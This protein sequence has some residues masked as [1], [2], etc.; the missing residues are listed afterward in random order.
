MK[1]SPIMPRCKICLKEISHS[2]IDSLLPFTFP[3][4]SLCP[5]CI[6]EFH[7]FFK[8]F[9]FQGVDALAIY[10][11]DDWIAKLLQQFKGRGDIEIANAFLQM[12]AYELH[13]KYRSFYIVPMPSS[14]EKIHDRGF[15]HL[16]EMFKC[17]NL[18]FLDILRKTD[19]YQQA[20]SSRKSRWD[21]RFLIALKKDKIPLNANLLLV[22][23]VMTTGATMYQAISLLKEVHP[24]QIKILLMSKNER[25]RR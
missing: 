7:P 14:D 6:K 20:A 18:P 15:N 8:R 11:Y 1:L 21:N 5:Q 17:L 16:Y 24:R 22:D 10:P 3:S 4:L 2:F 9:T 25:K 19:N 13:W 23:D 12:Y